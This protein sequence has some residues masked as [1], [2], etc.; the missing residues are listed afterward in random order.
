MFWKA[1]KNAV[2]INPLKV[3][4]LTLSSSQMTKQRVRVPSTLA[5]GGFQITEATQSPPPMDVVDLDVDDLSAHRYAGGDDIISME[6]SLTTSSLHDSVPR[7]VGKNYL[8]P[9]L[10]ATR[11]A[12]RIYERS[13]SLKNQ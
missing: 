8:P 9:Y 4:A 2:G 6:A 13:S 5:P 3:G 11:R 1:Q 7:E 12:G 10:T